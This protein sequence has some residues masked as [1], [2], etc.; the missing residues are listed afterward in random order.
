MTIDK[1]APS[2]RGDTSLAEPTVSVVARVVAELNALSKMATLEFALSTGELVL[3][4]LYDGDVT[5]FRSRKVKDARALRRVAAHPDLAMSPSM[6]YGCV[7]IYEVCQRLGIR[8]WKHVST[9]H[10]RLVLPLAYESQGLLL[11]DAEA[12]RWSVKRLEQEVV[13]LRQI[14]RRRGGRPRHSPIVREVR[15][16][17]RHVRALATELARAE[18]SSAEGPGNLLEAVRR[19]VDVCRECEQRFRPG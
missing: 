2:G 5:R 10:I 4:R 3:R 8:R 7:G 19:V 6:L 15:A 14:P 9:S 13:A 1:A 17:D 11:R 18:Y 16:L 12:Q